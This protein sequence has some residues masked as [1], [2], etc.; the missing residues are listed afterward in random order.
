M[1]LSLQSAALPLPPKL[2]SAWLMHQ[3]P[4]VTHCQHSCD[5]V[6]QRVLLCLPVTIIYLCL[7]FLH[8]EWQVYSWYKLPWP[9]RWNIWKFAMSSMKFLFIYLFICGLLNND[10]WSLDCTASNR[11]H[12]K[13]K[14]YIACQIS[15]VVQC[16]IYVNLL[17]TKAPGLQR[18]LCYQVHYW[19]EPNEYYICVTSVITY[20]K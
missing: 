16:N 12:F 1:F 5:R 11:L 4:Y 3:C 14:G 19:L 17:V 13:K 15:P 20:K 6:V 18:Q 7:L 9:Y 8:W 10:I 2:P